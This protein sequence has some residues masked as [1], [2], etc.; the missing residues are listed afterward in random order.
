[1]FLILKLTIIIL[2]NK[3]Y[4]HITQDSEI[5]LLPS[6][7]SINAKE[8][9]L[10]LKV[11]GKLIQLNMRK[12]EQIIS[13]AFKVWK[14]NSVIKKLS[15][16]KTSNPCYY[17]HEDHVSSAIINFCDKHGL[18]G[19]V[20]LKNDTLKIRPL[21]NDFA[22]LSLIDDFCVKEQVNLSFGKP[23]LVKRLLQYYTGSNLCSLNNFKRKPRYAQDEQVKY[24]IELAVFF[25]E[26]A[27]RKI[28]PFLGEDKELLHIMILTYVNQMQAFFHHPSLGVSIDISLVHLDIL[29]KQPSNLPVIDGNASQVLNSFCTYAETRNPPYDKDPGHWDISL[30]L[31][32][33][34]IYSVDHSTLGRSFFDGACNSS[35][36]CAI[37]EF[38]G[39]REEL[40]SG[41]TSSLVAAHEIGHLLGMQHDTKQCEIFNNYKYLMSPR[42]HYQ[43]QRTWSM[44]SRNTA[45][46]LWK[47]KECLRDNTRLE[48]LADVALDHSRYH[49]LPG[50]KWTAKAQ[51][52]L[53]FRDNDANVVTLL[54][55]CKTLECETPNK[56]KSYFTGSALEGTHC[57]LGKECR[58]GDC[59][60]VIEP[61]YNFKFCEKDRWSEWE[62]DSCKSSCL[63]KSKGVL[64]KRRLCKHQING[65]IKRTTNCAGPYYDMVLCDDSLLCTEKR[66][67]IHEFAT[68]KCTEVKDI[69][70]QL[71]TQPGWQIAHEVDRPWIA[72]TI[73]C[74]LK[75]N[76]TPYTPRLEM[77]N[78]GDDPYFPD[79]TWCH[80]ENGQNYYCRKHYCLP[81]NYSLDE[82][83]EIELLSRHYQNV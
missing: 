42:M 76:S 47:T 1:M 52:E 66:K 6:W 26:A 82:S 14:Y 41:F 5:I 83:R 13:P 53:F 77:L 55:I 33:I 62:E 78:F 63:E 58:G 50:R 11:F 32:G 70:S 9:L 34:N 49:D 44:C 20:F 81:E 60:P 36:S 65:Y 29:E 3:T 59:L 61:P 8:I 57:A 39:A 24:I 75:N 4:A 69:M 10:T 7:N 43:G 28:M 48:N 80:N 15:E 79:G 25:D 64:A 30:Y 56:S 37:V 51:C 71:D 12:N 31:T 68:M 21:R 67:T 17:N 35:K 2:L 18:E 27:Y 54:D 45:K 23:H 16:L 46:L 74:F 19:L 73:S 72:C 38:G 22:S 40:T